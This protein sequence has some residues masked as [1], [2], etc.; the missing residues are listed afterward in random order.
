VQAG[1]MGQR[2]RAGFGDDVFQKS[3]HNQFLV[4]SS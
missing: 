4:F 1:A 3:F 2:N